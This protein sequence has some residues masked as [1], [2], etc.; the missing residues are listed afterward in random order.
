MLLA[1]LRLY[2]RGSKLS[3]IKK[4]FFTKEKKNNQKL[5][6]GRAHVDQSMIAMVLAHFISKNAFK[7]FWPFA[8]LPFEL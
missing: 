1:F 2:A 5:V 3:Y 7:S 4:D 6:F 8:E